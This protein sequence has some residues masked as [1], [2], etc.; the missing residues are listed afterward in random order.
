[1]LLKYA[2]TLNNLG[3][4]RKLVS[5][6]ERKYTMKKMILVSLALLL[7]F[8]V[9]PAMAGEKA[10]NNQDSAAFQALSKLSLPGQ[11]VLNKM[12]DDQLA[13]VEGQSRGSGRS[14][15]INIALIRQR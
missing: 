13:K 11:T 12:T 10:I 7:A 2:Q 15:R 4:S 8:A 9:I 5:P 1:M 6:S 3:T 14:G